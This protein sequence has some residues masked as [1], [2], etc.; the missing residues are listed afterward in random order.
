M[1]NVHFLSSHAVFG[2]FKLY[3]FR[4]E[5]STIYGVVFC[6]NCHYKSM[7]VTINRCGQRRE[8]FSKNR[9]SVVFLQIHR[10]SMAMIVNCVLLEGV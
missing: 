3:L 10:I 7:S 9:N 6:L 8:K 4:M 2:P 5:H 1:R